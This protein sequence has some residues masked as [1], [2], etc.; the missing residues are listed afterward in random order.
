MNGC[1]YEGNLLLST[2]KFPTCFNKWKTYEVKSV[3]IKIYVLSVSS[4]LLNE[5]MISCSEES[6]M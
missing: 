1:D 6:E 3:K 5:F 4:L 2:N